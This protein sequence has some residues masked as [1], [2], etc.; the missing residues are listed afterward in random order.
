[1]S[2]IINDFFPGNAITG[3]K[4]TPRSGAF[5]VSINEK[6]MFSKFESGDFPNEAEIKSWFN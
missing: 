4:V 6:L 3:N 1:M 2:K 5:E